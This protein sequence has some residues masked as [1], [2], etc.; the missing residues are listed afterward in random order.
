MEERI[1]AKILESQNKRIEVYVS[2]SS[3]RT[4]LTIVVYEKVDYEKWQEIDTL[5]I[6]GELNRGTPF[7]FRWFVQKYQPRGADWYR[8]ILEWWARVAWDQIR[9]AMQQALMEKLNGSKTKKAK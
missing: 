3:A 4:V 2:L 1:V 5:T 7:E 6:H 8:E 9:E